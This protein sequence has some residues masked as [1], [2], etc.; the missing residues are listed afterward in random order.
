MKKNTGQK[1]PAEEDKEE[2]KGQAGPADQ[3][4]RD[5]ERERVREQI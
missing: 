3:N 4:T 5:Q 2:E 1:A